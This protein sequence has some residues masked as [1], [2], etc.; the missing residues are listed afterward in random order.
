MIEEKTQKKTQNKTQ[1]QKKAPRR[2][3]GNPR[4]AAAP[5][6]KKQRRPS[7]QEW[8]EDQRIRQ[9]AVRRRSAVQAVGEPGGKPQNKKLLVFKYGM[10][11]A[12]VG[13]VVLLLLMTGGSSK[14]FDT[15]EKAV[16]KTLDTE[17]VSKTTNQGLKRYY[18]LNAADYDGVML[19]VSKSSLSAEE[20]LLLKVK[21]NEQIEEV[22]NAIVSRKDRRRSDFEGYAPD[23]VALINNSVLSVRGQYI[24][25]VISKNASEYKTAFAKSL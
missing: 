23:E 18:G 19:Y 21:N 24:F 17:S 6:K 4:A 8:E 9:E 16:E 12:I 5:N 25:F 1:E 3:A 20:V 2:T 10:V 14:P 11:L 13:Y 15:I 22:Q 7:R